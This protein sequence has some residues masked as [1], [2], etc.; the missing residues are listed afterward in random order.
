M[1]S[2]YVS[3]IQIKQNKNDSKVYHNRIL[4]NTRADYTRKFCGLFLKR[5]RFRT[6]T[7]N[8]DLTFLSLTSTH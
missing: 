8:L 3:I 2:E 5:R 6:I 7:S 1:L 4:S